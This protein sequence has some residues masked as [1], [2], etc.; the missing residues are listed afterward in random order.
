MA[1]P[2]CAGPEGGGTVYELSPSTGGWTFTTLYSLPGSDGSYANLTMDAAGN[3]YGTTFGDGAY[4]HG[5]VFKL[6]PSNASWTYTSLYDFTGGSDG[7]GSWSNVTL[8]ANGNLYGTTY[9]GGINGLGVVWKIT[10]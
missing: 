4:G 6:T 1:L 10:P 2:W 8:D 3:L 5:N 9:A 7:S